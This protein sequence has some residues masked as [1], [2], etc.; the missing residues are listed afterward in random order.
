MNLGEKLQL[1]RKAKGLSQEQLAVELGLTRQA[2]SRWELNDTLPD[3]ENVIRLAR[4]F[5]VSTDYLLL[6]EVE[7]KNRPVS[8]VQDT[9]PQ[10]GTPPAADPGQTR[11]RTSVV[12][13]LFDCAIGLISCLFALHLSS[14]G[15]L[16]VGLMEQAVGVF[17]F[18]LMGVLYGGGLERRVRF[19]ALACWLLA[20]VPL[21]FLCRWVSALIPFPYPSWAFWMAFYLLYLAVCV[22]FMVGLR[23]HRQFRRNFDG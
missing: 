5:G 8:P 22:G 2:I 11:L 21:Y 4:F 3:T 23:F 9:P 18:E 7:G 20:P 12:G 15:L 13:G 6:D 19:Y 16:A 17:L 1:L 10:Q 14:P